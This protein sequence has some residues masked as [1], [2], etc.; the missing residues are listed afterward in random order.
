[1]RS[2][3]PFSLFPAYKSAHNDNPRSPSFSDNSR[4]HQPLDSDYRYIFLM[5]FL[6]SAGFLLCGDASIWD[7]PFSLNYAVGGEPARCSQVIVAGVWIAWGLCVCIDGKR[8]ELS[9]IPDTKF[10]VRGPGESERKEKRGRVRRPFFPSPAVSLTQARLN[11]LMCQVGVIVNHC[12]F[13]GE[14]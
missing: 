5:A 6:F 1:M 10:L 4:L 12:Q 8:A 13:C 7:D 3:T 2:P 11:F 9:I 14:Y